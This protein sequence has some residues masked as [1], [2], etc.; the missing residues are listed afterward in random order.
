MS[1]VFSALVPHPPLL[2]PNIGKDHAAQLKAT[3]AAF[4]RLKENLYVARP[5][6]ILIISP[7]GLIQTK[8][9]SMNLAPEFNINFEHFGDFATKFSVQGDVG[10][11][12]QI[13]EQLETTAPLQLITEP[14][15]DYGSGIPLYFLLP[16]NSLTKI[17]PLYYSGLELQ[18]HFEFGLELKKQLMRSTK[19]IAVIAS[20]DLSH[21]LSPTSP[22]G[23]SDKGQKFDQKVIDY[24]IRQ[25]PEELINLSHQLIVEASECGLKSIIILMGILN[26]INYKAET[27]AYE[28]PFGV[29]YLTMQFT[30]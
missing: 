18:S 6:T 13:K 11:A 4:E 10:L 23:Y 1:I 15:L 16:P 7:H 24:L 8:A 3:A 20:G 22:A 14:L 28:T 26:G 27:L 5:D 2:V 9:F 30:I 17:I 19:R 21:R 25:Q 29:G 12:Y